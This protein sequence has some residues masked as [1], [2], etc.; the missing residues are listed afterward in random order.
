MG[1]VWNHRLSFCGRC[2]AGIVVN[3]ANATLAT[4][5]T[6]LINSQRDRA[7]RN[8]PWSTKCRRC[9]LRYVPLSREAARDRKSSSPPALSAT[10][11]WRPAAIPED[12]PSG[13]RGGVARQ[14]QLLLLRR[15]LLLS[16]VRQCLLVHVL[17]LP[18]CFL[19][20]LHRPLAF[21]SISSA[22]CDVCRYP[23]VVAAAVDSEQHAA[24]PR[25]PRGGGS[26]TARCRRP[27][28]ARACHAARLTS[29]A[30]LK[31][32]AVHTHGRVVLREHNYRRSMENSLSLNLRISFP[33]VSP[34]EPLRVHRWLVL[35]VYTP[36]YSNE[37][38]MGAIIYGGLRCFPPIHI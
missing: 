6:S 1:A 5:R 18:Q 20:Q 25:L 32:S 34:P 15:R 12:L 27:A 4:H 16:N 30:R 22:N 37:T 36:L 9:S 21:A 24:A 11:R 31:V 23:A 29:V 28:A 8:Q 14:Q 35:C 13:G 7:G 2:A 26:A 10:L 3:I 17:L 19:Q 33:W 38:C